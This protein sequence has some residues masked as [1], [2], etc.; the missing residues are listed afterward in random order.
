MRPHP[1]R[2]EAVEAFVRNAI[3]EDM[4]AKRVLSIVNATL[5]V[6]RGA[7]LSV[8][9]IGR[10][11]ARVRGLEPKH[12]IK[13][14]DRLLSNAKLNVWELF[15]F[16]VPMV[17]GQ[18]T[19]ATVA[20]DW[21]EFDEDDQST[22]CIN[23]VSKHGRATP[24]LWLT[25]IKS[26]LAE[27]RNDT[28]DIVLRRLKEVLPEGVKVTVL[29]DRGFGDVGLYELLE[30]ELGFDFVI[31]FRGNIQVENAAGEMRT[32]QGW[33]PPS[34]RATAL[35]GAK[36]TASRKRLAQVVVVKRRG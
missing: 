33:L 35:R 7:S 8:A 6:I 25:A 27:N 9:T 23:L 13:Q 26:G 12:G 16:W 11:T 17:L 22:V 1:I 18:R 21:T 2:E 29:A 20:L 3:G 19:E 5:G 24:V 28:E 34:G 15:K 4:H 30:Y 31:R 14:V 32:A 10:A 36:V